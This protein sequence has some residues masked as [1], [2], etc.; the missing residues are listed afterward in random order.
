MRKRSVFLL[1]FLF[2]ALIVPL[3]FL[4][5]KPIHIS[6]DDFHYALKDLCDSNYYSIFQQPVFHFLQDIHNYTGAKFTLY[7][8]AEAMDHKVSCIPQ[9]NIIE[10]SKNS[11]WLRIGLHSANP[12]S[13]NENDSLFKLA[14]SF[15]QGSLH[16]GGV[17]QKHFVCITFMQHPS[18][19]IS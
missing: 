6:I 3:P 13:K 11:N 2:I 7:T 1:S 17:K 5:N 19:L 12:E 18:K 16:G 4:H 14:F 15:I 8:Y 10:L 9:K